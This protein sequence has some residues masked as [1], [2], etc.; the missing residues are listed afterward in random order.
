MFPS[1]PSHYNQIMLWT[2]L[3]QIHLIRIVPG[4]E[5]LASPLLLQRHHHYVISPERK[6]QSTVYHNLDV[7]KDHCHISK[8]IV[9]KW[10]LQVNG[11][12][13]KQNP[14][15]LRKQM[16]FCPEDSFLYE[17]Q[18]SFNINTFTN[19]NTNTFTKELFI[20]GLG[21]LCYVAYLFWCIF[22][23]DSE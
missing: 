11:F 20:S 8:D 13:D 22:G 18:W 10:Y 6:M 12:L 7:L 14:V 17:T 1:S 15:W 4:F 21:P 5:K 23:K 16:Q 3:F 9:H 2:Y 19:T